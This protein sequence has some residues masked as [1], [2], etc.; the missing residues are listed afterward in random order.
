MIIMQNILISSLTDTKVTKSYKC[1]NKM[2]QTQHQSL[3][4]T[5][6]YAFSHNEHAHVISRSCIK[7]WEKYSQKT[8]FDDFTKCNWHTN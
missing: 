8:I 5:K 3:G 6:L 7:F 1:I 2:A 4:S